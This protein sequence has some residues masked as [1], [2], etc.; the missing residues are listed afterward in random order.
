MLEEPGTYINYEVLADRLASR[1]SVVKSPVG[2]LI[3]TDRL[4]RD[5]QKGKGP[6]VIHDHL[7][8]SPIDVV[9]LEELRQMVAEDTSMRDVE[10]K[11]L[12]SIIDHVNQQTQYLRNDLR[13]DITLQQF[14][15]NHHYS[16]V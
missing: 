8:D 3:D 4:I 11:Q 12:E 6:E 7:M 9:S 15:Q 1:K 14:L 10:Q 2:S 13:K 16:S 5:V